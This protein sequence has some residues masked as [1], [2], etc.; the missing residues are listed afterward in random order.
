[1]R[2]FQIGG[3]ETKGFPRGLLII[4]LGGCLNKTYDFKHALFRFS[5]R[6]RRYGW[7]IDCV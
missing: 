6:S 4:A 1:M 2:A 7:Q 5:S 3:E